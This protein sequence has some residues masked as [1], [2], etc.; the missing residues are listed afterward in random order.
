MLIQN[1]FP[2]YVP[3]KP[4]FTPIMTDC[5]RENDLMEITISGYIDNIYY[6]G[7]F[8]DAIYF[9]L[10]KKEDFILESAACYYLESYEVNP[11][12]PNNIVVF[13]VGGTPDTPYKV[14]VTEEDCEKYLKIACNYFLELHSEKN[15]RILL[16][17]CF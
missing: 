14:D 5:L 6:N 17:K 10:V 7:L 3:I 13:E 1:D 4:R 12:N 16:M 2:R 9:I 15:T 11:I 8:L